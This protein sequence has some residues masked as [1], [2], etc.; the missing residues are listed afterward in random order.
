MSPSLKI[1]KRK[2]VTLTILVFNRNNRITIIVKGNW[3]QTV[4]K[5]EKRNKK[6]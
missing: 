1:S 4:Y 3:A 5:T 2:A 6:Y